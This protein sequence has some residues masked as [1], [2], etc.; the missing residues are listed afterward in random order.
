MCWCRRSGRSWIRIRCKG[1]W[2]LT[3]APAHIG[4]P[5]G[6]IPV[7]PAKAGC[8]SPRRSRIS[9]DFHALPDVVAS[10]HLRR[11]PSSQRKLGSILPVPV[12]VIRA[13]AGSAPCCCFCASS[14]RRRDPRRFT[15]ARHPSAT[16]T[17]SGSVGLPTGQHDLAEPS[18]GNRR[19]TSGNGFFSSSRTPVQSSGVSTGRPC[20]CTIGR[21]PEGSP[22]QRAGFLRFSTLR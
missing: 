1:H 3:S 12:L 6:F 17:R 14:P 15:L 16:I 5:I 20:A 13:K 21:T 22:A 2:R 19:Q 4:Y 10:L 7:I 9:R 8:A 18:P 11:C